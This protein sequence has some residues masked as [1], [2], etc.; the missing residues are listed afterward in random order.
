MTWRVWDLRCPLVPLG[1]G[2]VIQKPKPPAALQLLGHA[3]HCWAGCA[4]PRSSWAPQNCRMRIDRRWAD[5]AGKNNSS[6]VP[7]SAWSMDALQIQQMFL[8]GDSILCPPK[9]QPQVL[10]KARARCLG[11]G[12]FKRIASE[13]V[14]NYH[15]HRMRMMMMMMI[16]WNW[17]LQGIGTAE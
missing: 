6:A 8:L 1:A 10:S 3:G 17:E 5:W 9:K 14:T 13:C 4:Y 12:A 2:P 7:I 16:H 15:P 11:E